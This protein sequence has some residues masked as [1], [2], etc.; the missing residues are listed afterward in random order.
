MVIRECFVGHLFQSCNRPSSGK[1]PA[2]PFSLTPPWPQ[3][4]QSRRR[5]AATTWCQPS[6]AIRTLCPA[7]S[8][9]PAVI[10]TPRLRHTLC[11][12]SPRI[13]EGDR[14][15][16][17]GASPQFHSLPF[18]SPITLSACS[19]TLGFSHTP[20][21]QIPESQK[22]TG[23]NHAVSA[24]KFRILQRF[25][26]LGYSVFLSG[27]AFLA[28]STSTLSMYL[29]NVL[30]NLE[31]K[32]VLQRFMGLV[33]SQFLLG[34][35]VV[36]LCRTALRCAT[37][38]TVNCTSKH[39][40]IRVPFLFARTWKETVSPAHEALPPS[41][42]AAGPAVVAHSPPVL[43]AL[44]LEGVRVDISGATATC[45][46]SHLQTW[47]LCSC[48]TPSL[49]CSASSRH[50]HLTH[51]Q[52]PNLPPPPLADVDIVFLQDPFP[53]LQRDS[54][55]EGMT[56]GWDNGTA[57]GGWVAGLLRGVGHSACRWTTARHTVGGCGMDGWLWM[58]G[59]W[60]SG[61]LGTTARP[62]VGGWAFAGVILYVII[63]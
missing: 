56:D 11:N 8:R 44:L 47:T 39:S 9:S 45:C 36:G 28:Y 37:H 5:Q 52:C 6:S 57:Y 17:R 32:R 29:S 1:I 19:Q 35:G 49:A 14:Q 22:E 42:L 24:L 61:W 50:S 59:G 38:S 54:D 60:L 2:R 30:L 58:E 3:V 46:F 53:H 41:L 40:T 21:L 10:N 7:K 62:M 48:R 31:G 51:T 43:L 16:P 25:M 34:A 13:P 20:S 12:R 23:S 18:L 63:A 4:P 26:R 27:A 33:Y 15:Q 55:V